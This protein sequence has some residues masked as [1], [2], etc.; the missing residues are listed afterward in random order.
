MIPPDARGSRGR[1]RTVATEALGAA[2][3]AAIRALLDVAFDDSAEPDERFEEEDW[4]HAIGG[5]H[6]VLDVDGAI[7]AHASVVERELRVAG[8]PLRTGSSKPSPRRRSDRA[9]DSGRPS[10]PWWAT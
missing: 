5:T 3:V 8:R 2:D 1:I 7:I 4:Q 10:W 6:V 9:R